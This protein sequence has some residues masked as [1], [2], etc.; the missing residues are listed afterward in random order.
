ML[1]TSAWGHAMGHAASLIRIRPSAFYQYSPLQLIFG[2]QPNI[3]HLKIF[4]YAIYV[5][6]SPPQ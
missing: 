3:S 4:G 2:Q 6:I 5:L 1:P